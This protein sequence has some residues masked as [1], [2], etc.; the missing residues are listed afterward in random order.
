MPKAALYIRLSREDREK[1]ET[2]ESESIKNQQALLL[3]Y[4]VDN[5]LDIYDIYCDEDYSG[6][7]RDRPEFNRLI[8]DAREKKFDIVLA[9]TQSRFARDMEL[10]EKYINTLF[11]IWC[12]R[13]IGVVDNVN[14]DSVSTRKSRQINALVDQWYLEDLSANIKATLSSKRKAGQWVG[15]FAP[16][17]YMKDPDNKNHLV[18]DPDAAEIVRYIFKLY[19]DGFGVNTLAKKLNNEAIPNPA[20]YKKSKGQAFQNKNRECSTLWGVFSVQRILKNQVYLGHTVQ[21]QAEND[22]YKSNKKRQNPKE[23]WDVVKNTHEPIIDEYTFYKVQESLSKNRR[24]TSEGSVSLFA[25]KVR[26]MRCGGSMRSQKTHGQ[27]FY[28]CHKH[29]ISPESCEGTYVSSNVIEKAVLSELHALYEQ[30]ID[31]SYVEKELDTKSRL[32][33]K[34]EFI[35]KQISGIE[36]KV[37]KIETRFKKMYYDKL[38]GNISAEDYEL[39]YADSQSERDTLKKQIAELLAQRE[40]LQSQQEQ[41]DSVREII[42]KFKDIQSLDRFTVETLVDY[43]EVGGNKNNRIIKIHWNF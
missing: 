29:Y 1:P 2:A 28:T 17:G 21:G 18:V 27:R 31:E 37:S 19:L 8:D 35:Q 3:R 26:C 34:I 30:Y 15:A 10:V 22:S 43:I 36:N 40:I 23:E 9:K 6:S 13:F 16:F 33:D 5:N 39:F 25:N 20:A 12:V 11:P 38:E 4:C 7:D 42:A 24:S 14:S 32:T 41:S